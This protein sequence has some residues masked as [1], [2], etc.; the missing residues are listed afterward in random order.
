MTN[1][2]PIFND[3]NKAEFP[4]MHT[5][6]HLV[7]ATMVKLF[8][9]GRA[10]SAHVERKKS[11]LD[12]SLSR[13]LSPEEVAEVERRVNEQITLDL[14]VMT[15][16]VT[17][18]E[19]PAEVSLSRLPDDASEML[20]LVRVGDYD[21]CPCIGRHVQH[22][23]EIGRLRISSTSYKEGRQRLVFRLEGTSEVYNEG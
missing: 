2:T 12:Y 10:V 3:H 23:A 6:E 19:V 4:P 5:A 16:M 21:V 15:E 18:D 14:P 20:R 9:C 13:P 22:T 11:K 7:N 8:G 1:E 17:R